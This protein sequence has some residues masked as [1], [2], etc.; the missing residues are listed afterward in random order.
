MSD[1]RPA[2]SDSAGAPL[3]F[4]DLQRMA[5]EI[6][7][8]DQDRVQMDVSLARDLAADSLDVVELIMAV[9]DHFKIPLPEEE[10]NRM[11]KVADL[12][13]YLQAHQQDRTA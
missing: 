3:E 10:V 8:V 11:R 1:P 7:G 9:E 5:G 2:D 12:W 13:E 4:A 6:L